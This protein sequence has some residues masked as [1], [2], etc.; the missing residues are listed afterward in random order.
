MRKRLCIWKDTL[1][2]AVLVMRP[3]QILVERSGTSC[4]STTQAMGHHKTH[5]SQDK[6][7]IH[8][9]ASILSFSLRDRSILALDA[10]LLFWYLV[11]QPATQTTSVPVSASPQSFKKLRPQHGR[12]LPS[13]RPSPRT[14]MK[15][16]ANK[17]T[18]AN[19]N[20][21]PLRHLSQRST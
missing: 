5:E 10:T 15:A 2:Q 1:K 13:H 19:R 18:S 16:A 9:Q 8:G 14:P 17:Q 21:W 3:M 20:Q 11:A 12:T 4:A 6:G 7:A